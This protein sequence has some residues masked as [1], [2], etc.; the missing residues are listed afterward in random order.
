LWELYCTSKTDCKFEFAIGIGQ[1][2]EFIASFTT[3]KNKYDEMISQIDVR[4]SDAYSIDDKTRIHEVVQK[5][6]GHDKLNTQVIGLLR[7]WTLHTCE[8][9]YEQLLQLRGLQNIETLQALFDLA[10]MYYRQQKNNYGLEQFQICYENCVETCGKS[11]KLTLTCMLQLGDNL[12]RCDESIESGISLLKECLQLCVNE[13][14]EDDMISM[15]CLNNL[16]NCYTTSFYRSANDESRH[17]LRENAH[18]LYLK[19]YNL[20][21]KVYGEKD[22]QTVCTLIKLADCKL[23]SGL[24]DDF[25]SAEKLFELCY[26]YRKDLLGDSHID[27][28]AVHSELGYCQMERENYDVAEGI[29]ERCLKFRGEKLGEFHRDTLQSMKDV[30]EAKEGLGKLLEAEELFKNCLKKRRS[31]FLNDEHP[32]VMVLLNRFKDS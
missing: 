5:E 9:K 24:Q 25:D 11:S 30:A 20:R 14:G 22:P 21:K 3:D 10:C 1:L 2:E 16:A 19:C 29:F 18:S 23:S 13:L 27:T 31:I 28:L 17:I 4:N 12:S 15:E 26:E 6:V 8:K 7:D 32:E